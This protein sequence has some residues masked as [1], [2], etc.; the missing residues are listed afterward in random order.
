MKKPAL[1]QAW[2]LLVSL[3]FGIMLFLTTLFQV[4]FSL[5]ARML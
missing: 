4:S 3:Y 2:D 1:T 5:P